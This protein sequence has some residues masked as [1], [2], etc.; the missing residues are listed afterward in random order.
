[1]TDQTQAVEA[2]NMAEELVH[3]NFTLQLEEYVSIEVI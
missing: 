1:M 2:I 3:E